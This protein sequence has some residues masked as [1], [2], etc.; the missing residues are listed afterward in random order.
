[1]TRGDLARHVPGALRRA[2]GHLRQLAPID[3]PLLLAAPAGLPVLALLLRRFGLR[4]VQH[5]LP[6]HRLPMTL[7]PAEAE[8]LAWI[9]KIAAM[10]GPWPANCLQRSLLLWWYLRLRGLESDLRIGVRRDPDTG[11][12]D[13]HAWVEH[14]GTAVSDRSDV[15]QRYATFDQA[16]APR[17]ARFR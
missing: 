5:A 14:G 13:F 16:V 9:V 6:M 8:R 15:R 17:D 3:L 4:R 12:L 2:P 1:M 7:D 11:G 10:Y